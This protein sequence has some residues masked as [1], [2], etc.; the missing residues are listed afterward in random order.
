MT[1]SSRTVFANMQ[2]NVP[3]SHLQAVK[4]VFLVPLAFLAVLASASSENPSSSTE[5]AV[6]LDQTEAP[7]QQFQGPEA[8]D[9]EA[10][11]TVIR[12]NHIAILA[13]SVILLA[14]LRIMVASKKAAVVKVRLSAPPI[15]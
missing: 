7:S 6:E 12:K 15:P 3:A 8:Y 13:H 1:R 14:V 10:S 9:E 4:L 2:C 5:A 11:R